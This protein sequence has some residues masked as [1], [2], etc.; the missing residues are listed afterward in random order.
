MRAEPTH[1]DIQDRL[2]KGQL[3]FEKVETKLDELIGHVAALAKQVEP[4]S[5]DIAEIKEVVGAWKALG[6][7]GRF[8]KWAGG[9]ATGMVG[10]WALLK[11]TAKALVQ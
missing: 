9:I 4:I 5:S 6:V 10:I 7:F 1:A 8:A 2:E 3:R 11:V